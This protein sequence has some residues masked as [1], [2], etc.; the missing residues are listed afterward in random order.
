MY[1]ATSVYDQVVGGFTRFCDGIT[2]TWGRTSAYV[3]TVQA[4]CG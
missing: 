3:E 2:D 4:Q 1:Y